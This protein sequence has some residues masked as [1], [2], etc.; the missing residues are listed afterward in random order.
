MEAAMAL[1]AAP[2]R[3]IVSR[4]RLEG[5]IAEPALQELLLDGS[6]IPLEAGEPGIQSDLLAIALPHW[7]TLRDITLQ[8]VESYHAGY[9]LRRGI[10][11]EELKSKLKLSAR[12][13]NGLINKLI[14]QGLL[15]DRAAFLSK[16]GHEITFDA[17][18]QTKIRTLQRKFEQNPF[19]PPGIKDCQAELGTE[20]MNAL[21]ETGDFIP[22]SNDVVF[23]KQDF[24]E[25]VSRI[26][27]ALLQREKITLAEVR[28]LLGTSRKYAQALLE[29]LDATGL[30]IRDGDFRRLRKR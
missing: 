26:R 7:N 14:G 22:V 11:R 19:N 24:E 4:S 12:V 29:H 21:V 15:V 1:H 16:P 6:L 13:F 17:S 30:T 28:D 8:T 27:A 25:A 20:V 10:P 9:P 2:L 5:S 23:R 18:Q 3:E